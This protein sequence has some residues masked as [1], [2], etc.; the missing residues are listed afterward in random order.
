MADVKV[1]SFQNQNRTLFSG[2]EDAA[3]DYVEQNFPRHHVDPQAPVMD[4]PE[5]DVLL[6]LPGGVQEMY[7]GPEDAEPWQKVGGSGKTTTG[8]KTS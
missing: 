3:R 1:V 7:L 6:V 8:G 5:P 4:T 2:T